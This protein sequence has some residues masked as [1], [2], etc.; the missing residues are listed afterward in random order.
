MAEDWT[1][2]ADAPGLTLEIRGGRNESGDG[3]YLVLAFAGTPDLAKAIT[4]LSP[5]LLPPF[6]G[7]AGTAA[8]FAFSPLWP[9]T[10]WFELWRAAWAPWLKG[11]QAR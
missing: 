9:W 6:G 5:A 2:R 11:P 1:A 3:E 7:G 4:Q 8:P 10:M